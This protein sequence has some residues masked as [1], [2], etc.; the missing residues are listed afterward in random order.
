MFEQRI[1][2]HLGVTLNTAATRLLHPLIVC[3]NPSN[4]LKCREKR[5]KL[6]ASICR[7]FA[8]SRN[9][10]QTIVLP[11]HGRGRWFEPS[12]AHSQ[13]AA[14][15]RTN[16]GLVGTLAPY[17]GPRYTSSA[18]MQFARRKRLC[19]TSL[20]TP[21]CQRQSVTLPSSTN[22]SIYGP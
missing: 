12:I 11:S 7:N 3:S 15:C 22:S 2:V 17:V 13:K 20:T 10:Q 1:V 6:S 5:H 8:S 18:P 4:V 14:L 21:D 16:V 9:L 19:L